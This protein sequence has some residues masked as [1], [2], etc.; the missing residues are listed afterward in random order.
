MDGLKF[1][2]VCDGQTIF[3]SRDY[4][5]TRLSNMNWVVDLGEITVARGK[6]M[7]YGKI[8]DQAGGAP[9][10]CSVG[11]YP[12]GKKEPVASWPATGKYNV[13]FDL[14][15]SGNMFTVEASCPG[16]A[17]RGT[18]G[19]L[20]AGMVIEGTSTISVRDLVVKK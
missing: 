8:V 17:K 20:T 13:E 1:Q 7:I 11:V 2:S 16:Y 6:I 18:S 4:S 14:A 5:A 10:G 19:V 12:A 15:R 3:K 9:K